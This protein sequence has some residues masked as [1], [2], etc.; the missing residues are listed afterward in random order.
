MQ[1]TWI[2]STTNEWLPLNTFNLNGVS[3]NGVYVIWH[4]GNP[5]KVVYVGEGDIAAR[6]TAHRT[7][8]AI[9]KYAPH[10]LLVTWAYVGTQAHRDGI[11][12]YLADNSGPL[13][14]DAH[15]DVVP[16]AVNSPWS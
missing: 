14:G 6:L 16:I 11:E 1:V 10:G 15:P 3:G 9:Q 2:K 12:R 7:N 4:A 5:S 13:V 8:A